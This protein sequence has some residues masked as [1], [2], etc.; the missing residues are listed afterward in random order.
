LDSAIAS[1]DGS[2]WAALQRS[3]PH[4]RAP[5]TMRPRRVVFSSIKPDNEVRVASR[6]VADLHQQR[7]N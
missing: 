1:P 5:R 3:S 6:P 4:L 7:A 2:K